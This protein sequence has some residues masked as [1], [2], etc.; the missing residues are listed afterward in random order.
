M[1]RDNEN[2]NISRRNFIKLGAGSAVLV[3]TS[4]SM[5]KEKPSGEAVLPQRRLGQTNMQASI[6]AMGGGSALSMV[7]K[8]EDALAL[9]D[10]ARRKGINY[11]DTGSGY[12]R[13]KSETLLG[14]A[15]SPFRKD[16][17]LATKYD[18]GENYDQLMKSFEQSLQRFQSDYLDVAQMH[19]LVSMEQVD[20][21]FS[22]GALDT[23]VKLKEQKVLRYIGVTSHAH[24][25]ALTEAMKR[26]D[27]DVVQM[28]AN[29]SKVP[30]NFEFEKVGN[31]SF[32]EL[33][34]PVA[35]EKKVGIWA[36]KAT[37]QR[38]L[39]PKTGDEPDKADGLTLIRY[40]LSLPVHG[41]TLGMTTP[42]HVESAVALA[43]NLTPMT[44]EEM[45]ALNKKL[46]PSANPVT[47]HYLRPG[48]VDDGGW[49]AHMA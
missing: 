47:L 14:Q 48:Y 29:A 12:G 7:E 43:S 25:P 4:C 20:E 35:L 13:G 17:Y 19:G 42:E 5:K 34:L 31:S 37:A 6:L 22:S 44:Q 38:R 46:A 27:F 40:C 26:F 9:I 18:T 3:G 16:V 1:M 30:F 39:L 23:L 49:R 11:F 41:L 28:A 15:L 21:M 10:L 24:P 45:R 32:E 2:S 8:D 36:F 33:S